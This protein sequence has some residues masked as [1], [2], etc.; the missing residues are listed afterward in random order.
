MR[1]GRQPHRRQRRRSRTVAGPGRDQRP[2]GTGKTTLARALANYLGTPAIIRDEIKQG[3]VLTGRGE[4]ADGYADLNLPV[5]AVF[6]EVLTSLI[7]AGVTAVAEAAF[8]DK[9]WRPNLAPLATIADIRIV[10]CTAP[11]T[12]IHD[13]ITH[14]A[15]ADPHRHAH[16]DTALIT[17]IATN[18]R[19]PIDAFDPIRLAVPALTVNTSNGYQPD[20]AAIASFL[21]YP[22]AR[23]TTR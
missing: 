15:D 14:R 6:F 7:T 2:P 13:R 19:S 21:T 23:T 5:L 16:D 8:Q 18:T 3:M 11:T 20:L 17:S 10:H 22:V 4:P 12:V 1:H 9:L